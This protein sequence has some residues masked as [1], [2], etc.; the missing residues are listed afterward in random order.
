MSTFE[1]DPIERLDEDTL[2][3]DDLVPA[4]VVGVSDDEA[5]LGPSL[6]EECV[7]PGASTRRLALIAAVGVLLLCL[8]GVASVVLDGAA[9]PSPIH[10]E[11]TAAAA[12]AAGKQQQAPSTTQDVLS[13]ADATVV[14]YRAERARALH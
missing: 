2:E 4:P 14:R 7:R 6:H 8:A 9:A 13:K 11:R 10:A 5:L 12:P 3:L 1:F